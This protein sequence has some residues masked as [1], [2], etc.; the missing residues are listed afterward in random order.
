MTDDNE[1]V[2]FSDM[3]TSVGLK[4]HVKFYTHKKRN[5]LGLIYTENWN[6]SNVIVCLP[7]PF[8]SD[9]WAVSLTLGLGAKRLSKQ[10]IQVRKTSEITQGELNDEF[11]DNNVD[12]GSTD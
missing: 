9:H 12:T 4:L 3:M 10:M 6:E 7:R 11:N 8:I 5:I 1:A 2:A